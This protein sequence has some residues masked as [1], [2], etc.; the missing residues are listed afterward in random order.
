MERLRS[1]DTIRKQKV[2]LYC[3][4]YDEQT[5]IWNSLFPEMDPKQ[6][7]EEKISQFVQGINILKFPNPGVN[8]DFPTNIA[9]YVALGWIDPKLVSKR[10]T[11]MPH[12]QYRSAVTPLWMNILDRLVSIET[13][14]VMT[15]TSLLTWGKV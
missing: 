12:H 3:D 5:A 10:D 9:D 1:D 4:I 13:G 6:I 14:G 2:G 11:D 8:I 15:M 7:I